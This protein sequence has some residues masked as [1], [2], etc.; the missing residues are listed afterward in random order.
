MLTLGEYEIQL[1]PKLLI[2]KQVQVS[3]LHIQTNRTI[4][5]TNLPKRRLEKNRLKPDQAGL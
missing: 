4:D 5:K 3:N 1:K 2:L